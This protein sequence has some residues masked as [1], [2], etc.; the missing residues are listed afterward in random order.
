M[1][2]Y[3]YIGMPNAYGKQNTKMYRFP[4]ALKLGCNEKGRLFYVQTMGNIVF[5]N[6]KYWQLKKSTHES[7]NRRLLQ[8]KITTEDFY[9]WSWHIEVFVLT[10]QTRKVV[11]NRR[12]QR[13]KFNST[14]T[15]YHLKWQNNYPDDTNLFY[16]D[17][18]VF[19][20][21]CCWCDSAYNSLT[22]FHHSIIFTQS[23]FVH[24]KTKIKSAYMRKLLPQDIV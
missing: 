12:K 17:V 7:Y 10:N 23:S 15:F 1:C 6:T 8:T 18:E 24:T 5:W 9:T 16:C 4:L 19:C 21:S 2:C 11:I 14:I 22:R 13:F 20:C 3:T